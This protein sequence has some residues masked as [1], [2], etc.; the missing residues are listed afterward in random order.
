MTTCGSVEAA[1]AFGEH[2]RLA[3]P[4][5]R[6]AVVGG[7]RQE[8]QRNGPVQ[9]GVDRFPDNV[10]GALADLFDEL[11]LS[12]ALGGRFPIAT[13]LRRVLG[14]LFSSTGVSRV[15]GVAQQFQLFQALIALGMGIADY[16]GLVESATDVFNTNAAE[17][18]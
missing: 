17:L 18:E 1:G 9:P 7:A 15:A 13:R 16:S 3:M 6:Q 8:F 10:H 5:D 2:D 4:R 14:G 11:E 12:D